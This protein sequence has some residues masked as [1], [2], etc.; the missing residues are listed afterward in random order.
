MKGASFP[1]KYLFEK[2]RTI[3]IMVVV[4]IIASTLYVKNQKKPAKVDSF[5]LANEREETPADQEIEQEVQ[6]IYVDLKGAVKNPGM[7]ELE[8]GRRVYDVIELAGG[9]IEQADENQIN[10]AL[11][12]EDEMIVYIPYIG[13]NPEEI[14]QTTTTTG[15]TNDGKIRINQASES[16]LTTLPGIGPA[17]A[18][19]IIQYREEHGPFQAVEDLL[20][21]SGIGQKT[22]DRFADMIIV[23]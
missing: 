22:L 12:L 7:Y 16:E 20:N 18:E 23:K 3:I 21:I 15:S 6:S 9:L 11:R 19:A 14:A 13:E 1:M 4:V 5:V 17:K 8:E 10:Y 2:Y